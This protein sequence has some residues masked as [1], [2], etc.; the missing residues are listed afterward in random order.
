MR[1]HYPKLFAIL[2][3]EDK[4]NFKWGRFVT[5]IIR[6]VT[7]FTLRL[8]LFCLG[9]SSVCWVYIRVRLAYVGDLDMDL[10][11]VHWVY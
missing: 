3:F 5:L 8:N 6:Y 7:F 1:E 2:D 9:G 11:H 10:N 4:V